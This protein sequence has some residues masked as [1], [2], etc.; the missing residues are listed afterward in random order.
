MGPG[1]A[2]FNGT[3]R[4]DQLIIGADTLRSLRLVIRLAGGGAAL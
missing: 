4:S 1:N 2:E 3:L